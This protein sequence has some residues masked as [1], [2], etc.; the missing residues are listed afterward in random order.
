ML[1]PVPA[2]VE[3]RQS[4]AISARLMAR[5]LQIHVNSGDSVVAGQLLI[6]L[7]KQD[8]QARVQQ[9]EARIRA[10]E[11]QLSEAANAF[12]RAQE[13]Q[14]TGALSVA[15]LDRAR[16]NFASLQADLDGAERALDEA[17]TALEYADIRSPIEGRIV[18]RFA[19]PGDTAAPGMQLLTLYN[20]NTLRIEAQVRETLAMNLQLGQKL[21]VEIPSLSRVIEAEIEERVPAAEPGSRS[22]R[23]KARIDFDADFLPG[24]YA[25]LLIPAGSAPKILIPA[26]R[27]VAVG[28]QDLVWVLENGQAVRRFVRIGRSEIEGEVEVISGLTAGEYLLPIPTL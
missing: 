12:E 6:S 19:E 11:A 23:I 20:P 24:M 14:R 27:V 4:T 13:L 2:S 16:A 17:H 5:I 8:L 18:D 26:N 28:Q 7:E 25:R 9:S 15:D 21:Q 1:E 3:A 22:F 10:I